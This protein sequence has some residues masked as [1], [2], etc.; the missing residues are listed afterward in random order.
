MKY[1]LLS[2]CCRDAIDALKDFHGG[3]QHIS[4]TLRERR[5]L[6]TRKRILEEKGYGDLVADGQRLPQV[7]LRSAVPA[8]SGDFRI[9]VIQ[10]TAVFQQ[11][12]GHRDRLGV[13]PLLLGHRVDPEVIGREVGIVDGGMMAEFFE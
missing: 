7:A 1:P 2:R 4:D 9:A 3:A 5:R 13:L 11:L 6:E 8:R 12:P 10:K